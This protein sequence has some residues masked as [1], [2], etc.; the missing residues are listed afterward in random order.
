MD[1]EI[2]SYLQWIEEL[3]RQVTQIVTDLPTAALNWRPVASEADHA[4]NSL[5]VLA[6]H[7]AGAEHYW[8]YEVVGRQAATRDRP[9]EFV[10]VATTAAALVAR[11]AQ[12][13]QETAQIFATLTADSLNQTRTI[14]ARTFTVR[15]CIMHVIEHT[16][17]HLG[18]MQLTR[19]LWHETQ[20]DPCKF[21]GR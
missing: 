9:A 12:T 1:N 11:L 13:G 5:A 16:A 2:T 20:T 17:L 15:W 6:A 14:G 8:I 7:T 4:T 3:R 19:Q 18:H 10:T 21:G